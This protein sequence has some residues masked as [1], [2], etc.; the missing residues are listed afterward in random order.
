[1]NWE[2]LERPARQARLVAA[3]VAEERLILATSEYEGYYDI[4]Q[5]RS[6][7]DSLEAEAKELDNAIK[8]LQDLWRARRDAFGKAKSDL[9]E[10][11]VAMALEQ[12]KLKAAIDANNEAWLGMPDSLRDSKVSREAQAMLNEASPNGN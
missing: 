2:T 9:H 12:K 11:A 8:I 6:I 10:Y 5:M 7:V 3:K 1:M 4:G